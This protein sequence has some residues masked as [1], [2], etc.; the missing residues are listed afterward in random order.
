MLVVAFLIALAVTWMG[1]YLSRDLFAPY[2]AVP[3]VWSMAIVIYYLLPNTFYPI[4]HGFPFVLSVW[5][6][7]F[8]VSSVVCDHYVAAASPAAIRRQ[9]NRKVLKAYIVITCISMPIVCGAIIKQAFLEDPENMFR[10]MRMMSTGQDENIEM[11][12]LGILL[13]FVSL[14]FVMMFFSLL[15]FK[16]KKLKALIIFLNLLLAAVTMA[17]TSFLGIMFSSMYL[18]YHQKIIKIRHL[19][20]GLLA[21]VALSFIIQSARAAGE[22]METTNFLAL[23]LSSSMVAFDYYAVPCSSHTLGM[24]TFRIVYAVGHAL[25]ISDPPANT[26]LEFVSVPDITN[27]YTNMYP[28]YEDF[29]T[30]GVFVFSV[31]YGLF[32]GYLYK[33]SRTGGKLELMLYAIFLTFVMMEFIGEFIFT[34][35]STSL[36][37]VFFAALPFLLGESKQTEG[38][39]H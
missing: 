29:G 26:I 32:Y 31:V 12:N 9:P 5:L 24:H 2:V 15:Y 30:V 10:Y 22:E 28:F 19:V 13:Y 34:N 16:S 11:P 3:G 37:Y 21:F 17:K 8:F 7:G 4:S 1:W 6:A 14:G 35:F 18:C 38:N 20:Y 27:T 25:G 36:Q 39:N 33:K 23:Y